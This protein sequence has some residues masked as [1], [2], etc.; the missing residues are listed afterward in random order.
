MIDLAVAYRI[1]PGVS[2]SPAFYPQDKLL[3][4]RMCLRSFA[5][6][7]GK[8]K[9]RVWAILDGCPSEYESLFR[10]TL[11]DCE[12]EVVR[13]DRVGNLATFAKQIEILTSQT[14]AEHVYF[15]EDDYFYLPG[16]LETM[17]TFLRNNRDAD[18]VTPYDH[19]DS[20]DRPSFIERHLV[21]PD[22]NR[23]WRTANSTCLTFLTTRICLQQTEGV[24]RTYS[25]GN[26]DYP[27][28]QALTQRV[29]LLDPRIHFSSSLRFKAW[30][31]IWRWGLPNLLSRRPFRL[32]VPIPTLAT[33]MESS[34][35]AP[36]MDWHKV[37]LHFEQE[38]S[39]AAL[40]FAPRNA[41]KGGG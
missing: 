20:Y 26:G 23:Y 27:V 22:G 19:P 25:C 9:A 41:L 2:K 31:K 14:D 5:A 28:W 8:L 17:V 1:Y 29:S 24:F 7:F 32:W 15:A 39:D 18:F 35:L 6:S 3:L 10:E 40:D 37:F 13:T 21:R 4:S 11:R 38:W 16:S 34:G 30:L 12:L 36:G 33:H